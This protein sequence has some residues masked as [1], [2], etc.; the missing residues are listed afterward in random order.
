MG[1]ELNGAQGG[2]RGMIEIWVPG[3]PYTQGSGDR[4]LQNRKCECGK[5]G[6]S[7]IISRARVGPYVDS[8]D[9]TLRNQYGHVTRKAGALTR[10]KSAIGWIAQAA[11]RKHNHAVI[12]DAPIILVCMFALERRKTVTRKLPHVIPDLSKLV[13]AAEDALIGIAYKDD[14]QIV[15]ITATKFYADTKESTGVR[16]SWARAE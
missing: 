5:C 13:R 4:M 1:E 7:M 3:T 16:I 2:E 14:A 10:W 6:T 9:K 15:S 11:M 12:A 8:S